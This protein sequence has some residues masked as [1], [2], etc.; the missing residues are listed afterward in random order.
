VNRQPDRQ[1]RHLHHWQHGHDILVGG[2]QVVGHKAQPQAGAHGLPVSNQ[3]VAAKGEG[4]A[5]HR[6]AKTRHAFNDGLVTVAAYQLV[7]EQVPWLFGRAAPA[8]VVAVRIGADADF[9]D[10]PGHQAGLVGRH[11]A[12]RNVGLAPQQVADGVARHQ[13]HLHLGQGQPHLR[14]NGRQQVA[15]DRLAGADAHR[16][17]NAGFGARHIARQLVGGAV[18]GPGRLRQ[19][20]RHRRGHEAAAGAL[21]QHLAQLRLELG[22]LAAKGGLAGLQGPGRAQQAAVVQRG[23]EGAHQAPVE[24]VIHL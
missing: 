4:L 22:D 1:R 24:V 19:L 21:E 7:V 2:G 8:Q 12:Q 15:G 14:Q 3:V 6:Q 13:F 16:A 20:Q 18:H 11:H 9:G 17:R 10:A 5:R 23:Q